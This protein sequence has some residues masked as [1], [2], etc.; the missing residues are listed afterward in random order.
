MINV[1]SDE[2]MRT[3]CSGVWRNGFSLSSERFKEQTITTTICDTLPKL[4]AVQ[5][6]VVLPQDS[7][8]PVNHLKTSGALKHYNETSRTK[9]CSFC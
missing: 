6:G 2:T 1:N 9:A 8:I 5:M 4:W 7:T 3:V